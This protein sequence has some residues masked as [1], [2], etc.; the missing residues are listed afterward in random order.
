MFNGQNIQIS[1][2]K[3]AVFAE[4]I[5]SLRNATFLAGIV[6][7][8]VILFFSISE[9]SSG[10]TQIETPLVRLSTLLSIA[11]G[12]AAF[13]AFIGFLFG[14]TRTLKLKKDKNDP[15]DDEA[16]FDYT[17]NTNLE[18]ISDWLTKIIVGVGLI[19]L[20]KIISFIGN[21][22]DK[23]AKNIGHNDAASFVIGIVLY[24]SAVGFTFGFLWTRLCFGRAIKQADEALIEKKLN[25]LERIQQSLIDDQEATLL[26]AGMVDPEREDQT[27]QSKIDSVIQ[28]ASTHVRARVYWDAKSAQDKVGTEYHD[29]DI[30]KRVSDQTAM[31]F[32]AL[33]HADKNNEY[34]HNRLD[35]AIS[36]QQAQHWDSAETTLLEAISLRPTT[37]NTINGLFDLALAYN[38]IMTDHSQSKIKT[39]LK[40]SFCDSKVIKRWNRDKNYNAFRMWKSKIVRWIDDNDVSKTELGLDNNNNILE[41]EQA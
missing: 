34:L 4:K 22:S 9:P 5:G 28:S 14:I 31:V 23:V 13:T 39:L 6:C 7:F 41:H 17:P 25:D 10:G 2:N 35:L 3:R 12:V 30:K 16:A 20:T 19:E 15:N 11:I 29:A 32:K 18:E 38:K 8:A 37:G 40:K 33:I 26:V 21:L 1:E 24:A 36:Q 27:D